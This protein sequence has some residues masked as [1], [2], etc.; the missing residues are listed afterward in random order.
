M[1]SFVS[2]GD[3]WPG[4]RAVFQTTFF[5]GPKSV[6]SP[7]AAETPLPF[8]PRNC[9]QSSAPAVLSNPS[10]IKAAIKNDAN[11]RYF[12][13]DVVLER[14]KFHLKLIPGRGSS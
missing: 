12:I 1:R 10:P 3:E 4:G 7:V 8:G 2:T 14:S 5:S 6:T 13:F 9:G 11:L